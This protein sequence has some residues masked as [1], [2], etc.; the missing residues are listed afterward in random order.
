MMDMVQKLLSTVGISLIATGCESHL[1]GTR[2]DLFPIG[3]LLNAAGFLL[4]V[5]FIGALWA[6][7]AIPKTLPA[8]LLFA[9]FVMLFFGY[10]PVMQTVEKNQDRENLAQAQNEFLELCDLHANESTPARPF[11]VNKLYVFDA[12][13]NVIGE[14]GFRIF[15]D[16]KNS[17]GVWDIKELAEVV[18]APGTYLLKRSVLKQTTIGN[19]IYR[20]G[21]QEFIDTVSG[22]VKA[23]R[24]NYYLG[25]D[26]ARGVSCLDS[27]WSEGFRSFLIRSIGFS[28][29]SP[30]SD[31]WVR[32]IPRSFVRAKLKLRVAT[33]AADFKAPI[34]PD[35]AIYD[36]NKRQIIIDGVAHYLR[37]RFNDQPLSIVGVQSFPE[38]MMISYATNDRSPSALIQIR[39]KHSAQLLQEIYVKIPLSLHQK[40][41]KKIYFHAWRIAKEGATFK[42]GKIQFDIV[43]M[44]NEGNSKIERYARYTLEAPWDTEN[45]ERTDLPSYLDNG[46][47]GMFSLPKN[48]IGGVLGDQDVIG[49]WVSEPAGVLWEF[50]SDKTIVLNGSKWIWRLENGVLS[51]Q[52]DHSNMD[53]AVF[54][55]SKDGKVLEVTL[56]N[57]VGVY[58][59]FVIRRIQS[60]KEIPPI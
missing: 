41:D 35:G 32:A 55:A 9:L 13:E 45:I 58:E 2:L 15:D 49:Q 1:T 39:N 25:N 33:D 5:L 10:F 46:S 53:R 20:G 38:R 51:A 56:S 6:A 24:T 57:R 8:K 60:V 54:R 36:Y 43:Q 22:E 21:R 17:Q 30:R 14:W 29:G 59:P 12:T 42:D 50:N 23:S 3:T 52:Y 11:F 37:Q 40:E 48:D 27:N 26:F 16:N 47:Y 31:S 4:C 19:L 28:L 44:E 18:P 34:Y 7:I